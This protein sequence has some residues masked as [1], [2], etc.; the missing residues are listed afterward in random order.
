MKVQ[1][2][3]STYTHAF[4]VYD[5]NASF[6]VKIWQNVFYNNTGLKHLH[7]KKKFFFLTAV[8]LPHGQ[9]WAIIE[10]TASLTQC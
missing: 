5:T 10:G 4:N 2:K 9:L 6:C 8:W 3:I 1:A 7:I